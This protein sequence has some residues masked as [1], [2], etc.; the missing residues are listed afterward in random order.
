MKQLYAILDIS[1]LIV[2]PIFLFFVG[3]LGMVAHFLKKFQKRQLE[4]RADQIG[5][6]NFV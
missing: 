6:T 3:F 4:I 2:N 5:S 1:K